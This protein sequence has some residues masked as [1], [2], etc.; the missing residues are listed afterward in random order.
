MRRHSHNEMMRKMMVMFFSCAISLP[1]SVIPAQEPSAG[2]VQEVALYLTVEPADAQPGTMTKLPGFET[3][4]TLPGVPLRI[5][6]IAT[7]ELAG[8]TLQ[9]TITPPQKPELPDPSEAPAD[10]TLPKGT[11][12]KV[13][14]RG[15]SRAL[16]PTVISVT[17]TDSGAFA[18]NFTPQTT[19]KHEVVAV[20]ASGRY[21]GETSFEVEDPN[22]VADS[23]REELE[24]EVKQIIENLHTFINS[25][26][27]RMNDLPA[28]PAKDEAKQ[29]AEALQNKLNEELPPNEVPAWLNAADHLA[30]M[31][32]QAA[33][34]RKATAPLGG[35][36]NQWLALARETN[37][38]APRVKAE[39][40]QGN[41]VCDQLDVIINGLKFCDFYL[42]LLSKPIEFFTDWAKENIPTKL[43]GMVP[44]ARRTPAFQ[45][46]V[47]SAW[48]GILTFKPTTKHLRGT[49]YSDNPGDLAGA[50][51]DRN[52]QL[53]S[54]TQKMAFDLSQ[55]MTSRVFERYCQT[56]QGPVSGTMS[57]EFYEA[58]K[59]WWKYKIEIK[60]ELILRYPKDAQGDVIR[61]TG[62]FLG[63]A[64]SFRSWD[65]A[66]PVL[67]P[68]LAMGT[69]F[70]TFRQEPMALGDLSVLNESDALKDATVAGQP[71]PSFNPLLSVID[72][73]GQ[74]ARHRLTPAFFK[75]PV[76][77]ELRGETLRLELQSAVVDFDDERTKVMQIMLPVLSMRPT[78]NEY[79]LPY[80]G[81]HF[82]M[83]RA[84]HDGPVDLPVKRVGKIMTIER[85]FQRE[86]K[87]A[88]N[89]G[90]YELSI[91]VCN[92]DCQ[93]ASGQKL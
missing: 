78:I 81:A 30:D 32:R 93:M 92:P 86:R 33:E 34:L 59:T 54:G 50:K 19:G 18:T 7:R 40:T 47:E 15:P 57:A 64:M 24:K 70:K 37:A 74:I 13:I 88:E 83:L 4:T 3:L 22:D 28:S 1:T 27:Q 38:K 62:E 31:H 53:A 43:I 42:G 89:K 79:A 36:L 12:A 67:F 65:N 21:R 26:G 52:Y 63:N 45:Q 69:V 6:G 72:K 5:R 85:Q 25:I 77:A 60:G 76:R 68:G 84:M 11:N 14:A 17:V 35:K 29:K 58:G 48:K 23:L 46:G 44:V 71:L 20:D 91:R 90:V 16:P 80:K 61:L 8:K 87:T 49:V 41:V 39:L 2:N 82:M 55:Y 75:V 56:F 73:G 51:F 9:I 10:G 66:V